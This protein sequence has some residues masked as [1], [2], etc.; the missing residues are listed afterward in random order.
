MVE[1]KA[2]P[3]NS[4]TEKANEIQDDCDECGIELCAFTGLFVNKNPWDPNEVS[5]ELYENEDYPR[6]NARTFKLK[7]LGVSNTKELFLRLK[8]DKNFLL[9][10]LRHFGEEVVKDDDYDCIELYYSASVYT[11]CDNEN[12]TKTKTSEGKRILRVEKLEDGFRFGVVGDPCGL[13]WLVR[14]HPKD[15][16]KAVIFF[17]K[18]GKPFGFVTREYDFF[19]VNRDIPNMCV[20]YKYL[21]E[22]PWQATWVIAWED[23]EFDNIEVINKSGYEDFDF[24]M[25][26]YEE[27]EKKR[28]EAQESEE[29]KK[30]KEKEEKE[31]LLNEM[32]SRMSY[33]PVKAVD[34]RNDKEIILK[35]FPNS[36]IEVK[37]KV[38]ISLDT[39]N[40]P[41]EVPILKFWN[42]IEF[43][44][45]GNKLFIFKVPRISE[46]M[47]DKL[48]IKKVDENGF[49]IC[50]FSIEFREEM[51]LIKLNA[52]D[53]VA[54]LIYNPNDITV[55]TEIKYSKD[56]I[57]Y[58]DLDQRKLYLFIF[59]CP[60]WES[61][62][63]KLFG[64]SR[65]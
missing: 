4:Q 8:N 63:T 30:R 21:N 28:E 46:K 38:R 23:L 59:K 41:I 64:S 65:E 52:K 61:E 55:T 49:R 1:E 18:D 35:E 60:E 53:G 16:E 10:I 14:Q 57:K 13:T 39:D 58:I 29:E 5:I 36:F 50:G 45:N 2:N 48:E 17:E 22:E 31:K 7:D 19:A 44:S 32:F 12:S 33:E 34:V 11:I 56:K 37:T 51:I 54:F 3:Q 27:S 26:K 25:C 62:L 15:P 9:S 24:K 42:G 6:F 40:Q 20:L 47:K 43:D